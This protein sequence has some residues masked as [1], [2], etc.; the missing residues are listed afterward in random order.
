MP[1]AIVPVS[2][3]VYGLSVTGSDD[4]TRGGCGCC[5]GGAPGCPLVAT[6][7]W[8]L[9][10]AAGCALVVSA[11]GW[12]AV[13]GAFFAPGS[14]DLMLST[15]GLILSHPK[16]AIATSAHTHSVLRRIPGLH[17][18][19]DTCA[20]FAAQRRF[21][22]ALGVR[23]DT[24]HVASFVADAG[25]VPGR[26]VGIVP[27][28]APYHAVFLFQGAQRALV[29]R[30]SPVAMRHRHFQHVPRRVRPGERRVRRFDPHPHR[31]RQELEPL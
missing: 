9:V 18:E 31:P 30:E 3:D 29:R 21:V 5:T 15:I 11:A 25:D 19:K 26:A 24:D 27:N 1:G 22:A 13:A 10:G 14:F 6:P 2:W 16:V 12:I 17:G 23:H 4:V 7:G 28:I 20:V 8:P